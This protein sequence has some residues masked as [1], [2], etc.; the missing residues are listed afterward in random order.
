MAEL[1][2]DQR[3]A[4]AVARARQAQAAAGRSAGAPAPQAAP[5]AP[6]PTPGVGP[7]GM[8]APA[9]IDP[10]GALKA[11]IT[12]A[13]K[14]VSFGTA[15]EMKAFL[16]ASG[17]DFAK[18]YGPRLEAVRSEDAATM[19]KHPVAA[20][21]GGVGG[22]LLPA[23]LT[24]GTASLPATAAL[25]GASG[26]AYGF[27]EGEGGFEDRAKSM[28]E[29]AGWGTLFGLG[30]GLASKGLSKAVGSLMGRATK[31]PSL[32]TLRAVKDS[33]YKAVDDAGEVFQPAEL[34]AMAQ[35]AAA[36]VDDT[37]SYVAD[38]DK[39]TTAALTLVARNAKN[40]LTLGQLDK[41]RQGLWKRVEAAPNEVGIYE[42]IDSIDDLIQSRSATN[43]LMLSARAANAQYK[44]AELLELAFKKAEDQT[45]ST[46]S[47]GNILNKY[48][49]AVTAI[50]ND[51]KRARWFNEAELATM[52][53]VIDGS[54]TESALRRIGKLSPGGN[55]LMSML[56]LLGT[57]TAG[58]PFLAV[59][60]VGVAAKMGADRSGRVGVDALMDQITGAPAKQPAKVPLPIAGPAGYLGGR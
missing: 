53:K 1:T 14:G 15:D 5:A 34:A 21:V 36:A 51:P 35:K 31:R 30:A 39:Q 20:T 17:P 41:I 56:S 4:I 57:A 28:V 49:Q 22:S 26:A 58:S 45:A 12:G 25:S 24:G 7:F 54:L 32:E 6:A 37:G 52:Q 13:A 18:N 2:L 44:K 40:P 19:G 46:G 29:G 10:V 11:G 16:Q 27:G 48:K 8:P 43:D 23:A 42:V 3:R 47:G 50:V 55:G 60:A 9:G 59:P 38:V 33:A